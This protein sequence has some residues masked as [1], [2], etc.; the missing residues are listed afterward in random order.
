MIS[1][2]HMQKGKI[3]KIIGP[4]VDVEF[5]ETLPD[6][7]TALFVMNGDK[8]IVI[9]VE[10]HLG[11]GVV[12]T[13]AMDTTDGLARGMEVTNTGSPISVPVGAAT[14]GRIFNVLGEAID[15]LPAQTGG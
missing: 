12:R 13:V 8:K 10:Q 15:D 4:V 9:E 14:L 2:N 5:G 6:I 3:K 1:Q 11:N 7:Y